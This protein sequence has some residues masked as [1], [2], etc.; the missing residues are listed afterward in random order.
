M[1]SV[2]T[3]KKIKNAINKFSFDLLYWIIVYKHKNT[4]GTLPLPFPEP[5]K[6]SYCVFILFIFFILSNYR[7]DKLHAVFHRRNAI[8]CPQRTLPGIVFLSC[9]KC[10]CGTWRAA[11]SGAEFKKAWAGVNTVL[12]V[13]VR[14]QVFLKTKSLTPYE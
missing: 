12:M 3:L 7:A 1:S 11:D 14:L 5:G 13:R 6:N 8:W 10:L 2:N 4:T 9:L